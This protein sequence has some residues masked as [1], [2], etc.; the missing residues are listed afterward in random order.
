MEFGRRERGD[1]TLFVLKHES[2]VSKE[3]PATLLTAALTTATLCHA[4]KEF[5]ATLC[6]D[7]LNF[8]FINVVL[9]TK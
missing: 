1:E 9:Y 3:F 5:D 8:T 4:L 7:Q 2:S 6:F